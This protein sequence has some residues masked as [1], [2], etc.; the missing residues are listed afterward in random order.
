MR[1]VHAASGGDWGGRMV[2]HA[3]EKFL[4]GFIGEEVYEDFK[5]NEKE[6]WFDLLR[7]FE[8]RKREVGVNTGGRVIMHF[9]S[10]LSDHFRQK[11]NVSVIEFL[12]ESIYTE[13]IEIKRDKI[14]FSSEL[15]QSFF[16]ESVRKTIDHLRS[17]AL[18]GIGTILMVGGYSESTLLQR[19]LREAFSDKQVIVPIGASSAVLRGALIFGH[20]PESITERILK[21][22]YGVDSSVPFDDRMHPQSKLM[23]SDA[24]DRCDDIFSKLVEVNQVVKTNESQYTKK[25]ITL[26]KKQKAVLVQFYATKHKNPFFIDDEGCLCI[27]KMEVVFNEPD[28][29]AGRSVLLSMKF[30]GTEIIVEV[31]DKKTGQRQRQTIDFLG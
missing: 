13:S 18:M 11:K 9:P 28:E 19:A 5:I 29:E 23:K 21:F 14:K 8:C 12:K 10:S 26:H 6:D 3:F 30:G 2:D 24:G 16:S 7:E 31:E 22:T 25:F 27:G 4:K 20:N 17:A 1:E 15:F